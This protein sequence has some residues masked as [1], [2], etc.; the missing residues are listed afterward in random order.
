MTKSEW[1]SLCDRC[2]RCCLNKLDD[3]DE[4]E[5]QFTNV[6]CQLLDLKSCNCSDYPNRKKIVTDCIS[7]TAKRIEKMNYLPD[8]CAYRLLS[9]GKKL[10]KW[11]PLISGTYE[12]VK[13]AKISVS[14]RVILKEDEIVELEDH[15]IDWMKPVPY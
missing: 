11:H 7:L 1:E 15:I 10:F 3:E 9:E 8:T 12:S 4:R 14:C 5:I 13:E 2:G 6:A